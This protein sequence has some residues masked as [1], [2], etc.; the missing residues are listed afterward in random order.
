MS[1]NT[2]KDVS[3]R[4]EMGPF[5]IPMLGGANEQLTKNQ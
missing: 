5:I 2:V 4:R 3:I 1:S